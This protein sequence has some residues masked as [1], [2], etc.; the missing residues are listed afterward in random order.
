MDIL[1]L[2]A[3]DNYICVNKTLAKKI[4]LENTIL[5]GALCGY[6]RGFKSEE[7]YH[8]Q[9]KIMEDTCLSEYAVR[10]G[11]KAL[12][13]YDLISV[14]KKGLPAK[15]YYKI[16]T[17]TVMS[18]LT[19]SGC[20]NDTT[21]SNENDTTLNN[22]YNN[23]IS[24]NKNNNKNKIKES[25]SIEDIL[26]AYNF[27]DRITEAINLWLQY[28]KERHQKYTRTS[29]KTLLNRLQKDYDTYG[30]QYV[31]DSIE[32]SIASNYQGIFAPK[33]TMKPKTAEE[34]KMEEI[35]KKYPKLRD[36]ED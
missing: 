36:L 2:L 3:N 24:D 7:F 12:Q 13:D 9:D 26:I 27:N 19:T 32:S 17:E 4:G 31:I 11:I 16:K 35:Y 29:L 18:M 30:E 34:Q 15:Y 8:E 22:V 33:N 20:E 14:V 28:K 21:G 23:N 1:D 6:Q 25:G 5:F 10:K